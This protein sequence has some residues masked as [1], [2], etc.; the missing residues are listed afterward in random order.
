MLMNVERNGVYDNSNDVDLLSAA[1]G[2][3]RRWMHWRGLGT[4]MRPDVATYVYI[5]VISFTE[6]EAYASRLVLL[7]RNSA[8]LT[9]AAPITYS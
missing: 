9:N 4:V 6:E 2:W 3:V 8:K 7:I 1:G 5:S